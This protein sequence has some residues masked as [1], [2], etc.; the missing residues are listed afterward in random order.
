MEN[1]ELE[2]ASAA[3]EEAHLIEQERQEAEKLA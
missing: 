3:S 1:L 2:K